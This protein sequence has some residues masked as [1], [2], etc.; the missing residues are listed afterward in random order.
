MQARGKRFGC[1]TLLSS[2]PA[3]CLSDWWVTG[4][5]VRLVLI[6]WPLGAWSL[7]LVLIYD[8]SLGSSSHMVTTVPHSQPCSGGITEWRVR[9]CLQHQ[10]VV[11]GTSIPCWA[12]QQLLD[13]AACWSC[14]FH[15]ILPSCIFSSFPPQGLQSHFFKLQEQCS[16]CPFPTLGSG[17]IKVPGGDA[18]PWAPTG[19]LLG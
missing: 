11:P 10:C 7:V 17:S 15:S 14:F 1:K 3:F 18:L 5:D 2:C 9:V 8:I 13:C 4:Q 12:L 19:Q 6:W 16:L